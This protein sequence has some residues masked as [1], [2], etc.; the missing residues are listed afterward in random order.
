MG[1]QEESQ[2]H[3]NALKRLLKRLKLQDE[4]LPDLPTW[5]KLLGRVDEAFYGYDEERY[6]ME[7]SLQIS[8]DEMT[9][10]HDEIRRS[11]ATQLKE[12][13]FKFKSILESLNDGIC[14]LNL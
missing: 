1:R 8:S 4:A 14:E 2:N 9:R 12:Q 3:H 7:R 6:L 13:E 10:L 11:S 5:Q